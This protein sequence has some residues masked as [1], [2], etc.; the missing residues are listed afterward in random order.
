[1]SIN[2][3]VENRW[4]LLRAAKELAKRIPGVS[5]NATGSF[6]AT[7]YMPMSRYW[8]PK[9]TATGRRIGWF[10]HAGES[11]VR[12][13]A[14]LV[15]G[16]VAMNQ[17]M[18]DCLRAN[19]AP[20]A[21]LIRPGAH[22]V[23]KPIRFGVVGAT[24]KDGRK[25]E[26]F[27]SRMMKAGYN[28]IGH[29]TGW[30]CRILTD[31][32]NRLEE[33]YSKIDYLVVTSTVEGGPMPLVDAIA[34]GVPVIAPDV[35]WAWEYPVIRY[36]R[37]DWASLD[38]VLRG[39]TQAPTWDGW[40]EGHRELFTQ[41]GLLYDASMLAQ[42]IAHTAATLI[43]AEPEKPQSVVQ[44][45]APGLP[46]VA[47]AMRT[48]DRTPRPNYITKT[49]TFL[50]RQSHPERLYLQASEPDLTWLEKA[51]AG[52]PRD[53]LSVTAASA[54]K[55]P[56]NETGLAAM[57]VALTACPEAEWMLLLEDDLRFCKDFVTSVRAWI[58][59]HSRADRNVY[60]FFG[61]SYPGRPGGKTTVRAFDHPLKDLRAS[62]AILWRRAD[63]VAFMAW[64][65]EHALTWRGNR[66]PRH[67]QADPR[68]AFDKLVAEWSLKTWPGRPGVLSWPFFV[69]HIG[70]LSSLHKRGVVDH[71]FYAGDH[72][73]YPPPVVV[74]EDVHAP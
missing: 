67:G 15:Q 9:V 41:M 69:D 22:R 55:L 14:P 52:I 2:I 32:V 27:V 36:T 53:R 44:I 57:D 30:P 16:H 18:L 6:D 71:R 10:T 40:A 45:V 20:D 51:L 8:I 62:Q 11:D 50:F 28:V 4:I 35:G 60:R 70:E 23:Q 58:A 68:I 7:Y 49:L 73:A 31:D 38:V 74:P 61:F 54:G 5:V 39:L 33:F 64:A 43:A 65:R 42:R 21:V 1:M 63:A 34:N 46:T 17:H 25:G 48:C 47:L 24:K 19:G 56:P 26:A 29:G 12:E 66:W 37:G 13:F 59:K 3:I 72:W